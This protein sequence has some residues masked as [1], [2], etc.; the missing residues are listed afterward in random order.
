MSRPEACAY[1]HARVHVCVRPRVHV[2]MC[3]RMCARRFMLFRLFR[4]VMELHSHSSKTQCY[5]TIDYLV[6]QDTYSY[7]L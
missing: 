5:L 7:M 2:R 4:L 3:P 1:V 6:I